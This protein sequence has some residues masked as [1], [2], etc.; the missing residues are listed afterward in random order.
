MTPPTFPDPA[1]TWN[2]RFA[3]DGFVFGTQPN[4]W[5]KEHA[6]AWSKP[7]RILSIADGEGRNSVWLAGEGHCVEAF[8]ISDVGVAKARRLASE[9]NVNVNFVV[10]DCDNFVW[11]EAHYDGIAAIF[12]QFAD[13][14]MRARLFENIVRSLKPGGTLILQGYTTKQLDYKTGGPPVLSHLYT[15]ALLRSLFVDLDIEILQEYEAD[16]QEG[17]GHRGQSALIGMV[18]QRR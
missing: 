6:S 3:Q 13:P 17:A 5:L 11:Q 8:D 4:E 10:A 15:E 9:M 7:S 18:A 16:V 14:D 2:S 1:Q 12:V